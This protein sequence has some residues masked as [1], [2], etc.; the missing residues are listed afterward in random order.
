MQS[1]LDRIFKELGTALRSAPPEAER[2]ACLASE[3]A[4]AALHASLA[5]VAVWT[6]DS[7][8]HAEPQ[9]WRPR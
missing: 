2:L 5:F 4:F 9:T 6:P 8:D 1:E 7:H 3:L